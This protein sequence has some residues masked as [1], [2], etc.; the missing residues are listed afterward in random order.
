MKNH[1]ESPQCGEVIFLFTKHLSHD[2]VRHLARKE[3]IE[4]QLGQN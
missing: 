2:E 4:L 3:G 1:I